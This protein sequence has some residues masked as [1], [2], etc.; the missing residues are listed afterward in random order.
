VDWSDKRAEALIATILFIGEV[1]IG[2]D[3]SA[4]FLPED[5]SPTYWVV[6][7]APQGVVPV[8]IYVDK[9]TALPV[10]FVRKPYDDEIVVEP[11]DWKTV[12][13]LKI[14]FTLKISEGAEVVE[15]WTLKEFVPGEQPPDAP[16]SRPKDGP[17]D[18]KLTHGPALGIPF[19]FENDHLMIDVSVNGRPPIW[20]MLDS[21]A[22]RSSTNRAWRNSV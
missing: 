18:S 21:G 15:T 8:D 1:P 2:T 13:K 22:A 4:Q 14:P 19:N 16:F 12:K 9:S 7:V 11:S 5:T 10:K 3:A 17:V 6:R 20:F